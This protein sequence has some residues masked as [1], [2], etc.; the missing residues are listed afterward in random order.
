MVKSV[1]KKPKDKLYNSRL[2]LEVEIMRTLDH[3]NIVKLYES[4]EDHKTVYLVL[5]R[6][7]G[8]NSINIPSITL[9]AVS[10]LIES[11]KLAT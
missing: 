4:F 8:V 7:A 3:P 2:A 9:Q 1:V 6:L 5:E 10:C 11:L